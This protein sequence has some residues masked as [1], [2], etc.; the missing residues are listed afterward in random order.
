MKRKE[1]FINES[2]EF[3]QEFIDE[4]TTVIKKNGN[5]SLVPSYS[6]QNN[7]QIFVDYK[8]VLRYNIQALKQENLNEFISELNRI[9]N[10]INKNK[11]KLSISNIKWIVSKELYDKSIDN[12]RLKSISWIKDYIKN[13]DDNCMIKNITINKNYHSLSPQYSR[14]LTVNQSANLDITPSQ[15]KQDIKLNANYI[16]ECK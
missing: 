12:M 9:K 3:F 11:I 13:L 7:K 14:S 16:L 5:Y 8:G 2:M 1:Y 10:N 4:D 6:Y 15:T